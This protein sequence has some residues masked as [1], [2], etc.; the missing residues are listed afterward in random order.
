MLVF[1][2]VLL[3]RLPPPNR[4]NLLRSAK[5]KTQPHQQQQA[6]AQI[7]TMDLTECLNEAPLKRLA[8]DMRIDF[9]MAWNIW[10]IHAQGRVPSRLW[11][12]FEL[13]DGMPRGVGASL[14]SCLL[15]WVQALEKC[16][17]TTI[18]AA[19]GDDDND[20][21]VGEETLLLEEKE[22]VACV[23]RT[24]RIVIEHSWS[25]MSVDVRDK[26]PMYYFGDVLA[27]LSATELRLADMTRNLATK[28]LELRRA[29]NL[30]KF[31]SYSG[32]RTPH[33][34][35]PGHYRY[36]SRLLG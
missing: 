18:V 15:A 1:I 16:P 4:H 34:R 35:L 30:I 21:A 22:N 17:T 25:K 36:D 24:L 8:A 31:G 28:E 32:S 3:V 29:T 13:A 2:L 12:E 26:M 27:R 7:F 11:R 10:Q 9:G 20:E 14:D 5:K 6:A 23:K 19:A 33:G